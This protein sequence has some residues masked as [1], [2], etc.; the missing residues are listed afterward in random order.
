MGVYI[1]FDK[2]NGDQPIIYFKQL[3]ISTSASFENFMN[4]ITPNKNGEYELDFDLFSSDAIKIDDTRF[5]IIFKIKNSSNMLLCIFDFN[6]DYTGIR[7]K[8]YKLN[9]EE[10]NINISV[11]IKSFTFKEYFGITFYD[12]FKNY[13]GYLFF[14]YL[15]II[16]ENKIDTRTIKI[17]LSS[18]SSPIFSFSDNIEIQNNI[19]TGDI[20][21]KIINFSS[22]SISG[23]LINSLN[24][25]SQISI[26]NILS[27]KDSLIF[28]ISCTLIGEY[29]LEF[30]PIIQ[31]ND[32]EK[33][34]FGS[35]IENEK[36]YEY[37]TKN[38]FKLLYEITCSSDQIIYTKSLE[39][40]YCLF[41][42]DLFR[43]Y[44]LYQD[45][46]E[47][48]CYTSCSEANNGN[49]YLYMNTC[50]SKCP[51]NY[52]P[53]ENNVCKLIVETEKIS[54]S[55]VNFDYIPS[56]EINQNT[57]R[58]GKTSIIEN[59]LTEQIT[60]SIKSSTNLNYSNN[61]YNSA[62]S[63]N[64][65]SSGNSG[66][67]FNSN[68][69]N[70]LFISNYLNYIPN[71]D[72]MFNSNNVDN[73]FSSNYSYN[74][75]LNNSNN[76]ENSTDLYSTNNLYITNIFKTDNINL[77]E[78]KT[79]FI[80]NIIKNIIKNYNI[81]DSKSGIIKY[82]QEYKTIISFS[83]VENQNFSE[84]ETNTLIDLGECQKKLINYYNITVNN[85]S[86]L[87]ILKLI[88]GELGKKIPKIE[89]EVYYPLYN[90]SLIKL[91]LEIC[92]GTKIHISIPV[93][94]NEIID[95]YNSS[96]NYYND[97][98]YKSTSEKG[99]D[100][101]L[102]DRRNEFIDKNMT[103]CEEHCIL[104]DYNY[105]L[106]QVKC[107]CD[108]KIKIPLFEEIRFNKDEL[109]K[110]FTNINNLMNLNV[111]KCYKIIF[112][113]N[114]IINNF[115]FYFMSIII[116][117]FFIF[118][119]I[120]KYKSFDKLKKEI[121]VIITALKPNIINLP[122]GKNVKKIKTK[123]KT[124]KKQKKNFFRKKRINQN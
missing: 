26:N 17:N 70:S 72:N 82:I 97:H 25:N 92:K 35:Y 74:S 75:N 109:R 3:K 2:D 47:K 79:E 32:V 38:P 69:N 87:Y 78:N 33:E 29:Y 121:E 60:N 14:N 63:D 56:T 57:D 22:P 44:P 52:Y 18:E 5:I 9:F 41:S 36:E 89:Y 73:S 62:N 12:S 40:Q 118:L 110:S 113:K 90:S 30:L 50:T 21:I 24:S 100:I 42:C 43:E 101:T 1:F 116:V 51:M 99:T 119:I 84:N 11:N 124:K 105:E 48:K 55:K 27:I 34:I 77:I 66:D 59:M 91:D 104:I 107:S 7:V 122:N 96:G 67:L 4:S 81:K 10:I 13:P 85:D 19:F 23:V 31:E 61:I 114:N 106:E 94:I 54:D 103:L 102:N 53:D 83:S 45:E 8:Y 6:E 46:N 123:K 64:L 80:K 39:E 115:G 15:I 58:Y 28:D 71:E 112:K 65:F 16:S 86:S 93:K 76:F 68:N 88:V 49:I 98:C 111:M 108:V 37:Y 117:L 95:K 20:K 120:F